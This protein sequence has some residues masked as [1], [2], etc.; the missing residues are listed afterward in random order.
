[1]TDPNVVPSLSTRTSHQQMRGLEITMS[2]GAGV[3]DLVRKRIGDASPVRSA[4]RTLARSAPGEAQFKP[5][6]RRWKPS[7]APL[8]PLPKV[9]AT[10]RGGGQ[11]P[12]ASLDYTVRN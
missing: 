5:Y 2:A 6:R 4:D 7:G 1:M 3:A 11:M 9:G 8:A 10:A 12:F